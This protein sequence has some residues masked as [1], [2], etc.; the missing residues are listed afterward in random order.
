LFDSFLFA[1]FRARGFPALPALP[2]S[3]LDGKEGSPVR[4]RKRALQ[5]SRVERLFFASVC[6]GSN[7][8]Y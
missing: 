1:R 5:S 8:R 2:A 3:L 4:V 6:T 7:V